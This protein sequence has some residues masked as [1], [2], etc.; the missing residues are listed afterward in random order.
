M[1]DIAVMNRPQALDVKE[2][3]KELECRYEPYGQAKKSPES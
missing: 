3:Q 1:D 2:M